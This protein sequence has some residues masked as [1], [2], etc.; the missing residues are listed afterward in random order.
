MLDSRSREGPFPGGYQPAFNAIGSK[1]PTGSS[2]LALRF[3]SRGYYCS[4]FGVSP[5]RNA[6][7]TINVTGISWAA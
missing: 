1:T 4:V 6:K 3:L 2:S 5:A 7:I